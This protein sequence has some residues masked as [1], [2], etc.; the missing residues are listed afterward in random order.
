MIEVRNLT[1]RYGNIT[2]IDNVSFSVGRGEV[3]GFLGP[4]GAGKTTTMRIITGYMPPTEG[5]VRI[6]NFDVVENPVKAKERIG[7]LPENPPLYNDMTVETYLDFV[8]DIKKV[9]DKSK[10]S[11]IEFTMERCA[12]AEVRKRIIRNLSKGYRQRIGIAQALVHDPSVLVLDEPTV[13]LDPKQIIE[14]RELIKSLSAERTVILSTHILPEVS[15]T[16]T[17][18]AII[19]R[20]KIALEESLDRLSREVADMQMIFLKVKFGGSRV[21]DKILAL[22]SVSEVNQG[23]YGEFIVWSKDKADVREELGNMAVGN[24][25][26]LLEMRTLAQTLEEVFLRVISAEGE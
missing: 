1:K 17:R 9:P 26:G 22:S 7:Y 23:S 20:G 10:K 15:M 21:K 3:L 12:I 18:V 25:W 16:C 11:R 19:N 13:G 24:G 4:N 8:A 2:A 5:R 6:D 14:I